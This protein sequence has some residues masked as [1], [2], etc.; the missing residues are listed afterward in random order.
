M[1]VVYVAGPFRGPDAW[2][3]ESNIRRAETLALEVWRLGAAVICPHANTRFFHGAAPDAVWLEGDLEMLRRCDAVLFTPDWER[4]TGA[5]AEYDEACRRGI[6]RLFTLD[7]VR[8]FLGGD[9]P[10]PEAAE[11]CA[12]CGF[13]RGCLIHK[14]AEFEDMEGAE[15]CHPFEPRASTTPTDAA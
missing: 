12:K 3:I 8:A 5:R 13:A 2:A 4:S 14:A 11:T 9:M 10:E 7:A 1:K 15:G 6:P